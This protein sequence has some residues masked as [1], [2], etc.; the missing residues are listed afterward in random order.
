MIYGV[1]P[2]QY[3]D[4]RTLARECTIFQYLISDDVR[5][6]EVLRIDVTKLI[7]LVDF[8]QP[9]FLAQS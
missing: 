1:L 4:S 2:Y 6:N 8:T 9:P 3:R 5:H 7:F